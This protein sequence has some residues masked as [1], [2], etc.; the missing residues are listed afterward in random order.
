[1]ITYKI[2][3]EIKSE[4][5]DPS[6]VLDFVNETVADLVPEYLEGKLITDETTV[7][8]KCGN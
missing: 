3:L 1:M 6:E 4:V 5:E 2:T 8:V 7:E